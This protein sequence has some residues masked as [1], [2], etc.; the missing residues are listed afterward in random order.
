MTD[1]NLLPFAFPAVDGKKITAAFDGGRI[2][3]NG[4]VMV[5]ATAE[6]KLGIA[7]KLA[8]VILDR[9]DPER[10]THL[11][12]DILRTRIF[13]IACGYEDADDLDWLRSDPAFKLACGRLP[14]SGRDLCSQPTMSRWENAPSLREI[15]RLMGVLVDLYCSSYATPPAAV[16]LDVDDTVDV[17]HGHQQLSLFNAHY[18]ER[19]FLPIH[20][21]DTATSRPVAVLLRPGKTPSGREI[22]GHLRRLLRRIR[23]HWPETRITLRGDSHYG[24]PDVMDFCDE[25]GIDFVFGLAGNAALDRAVDIAADDIRTRRALSQAPLLRGYAETLYQAASWSKARRTC[26]RIE[27]TT[28]GLDIRFVVTSLAAGSAEHIY[29]TLYCARG[30]AE[31]LIKLHKS[32]LASDRTSCRSPLANQ[33]RLILHS[34]AYW[35][36][37]TMR[38]AIPAAHTLAKAEFATIRLRL[39]KLGARIIETAARVRLAF[40]A[41]CPDA[42]LIRQLATSIVPAAP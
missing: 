7:A 9:R 20:V 35:L 29:D 33:M 11:L 41:A 2:T 16:T 10:V 5:L 34:A 12:A 13:A 8:A 21:Y 24:R 4:G 14:D 15:I 6:R 31:N 37:L 38:D 42:D 26:A 28:L 23:R 3:S 25:N 17:V 22:V 18:D 30:Q 27:A 40:A 1:G 32:Q 39:L 36:M 19:C